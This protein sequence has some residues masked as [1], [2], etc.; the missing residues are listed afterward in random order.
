[1][2]C[3]FH[4]LFPFFLLFLSLLFF[5]LA[6]SFFPSFT[7]SLFVSLSLFFFSSFFFHLPTSIFLFPFAPESLPLC[8]FTRLFTPLVSST[9]PTPF[10][11][12]IS[13]HCPSIY[14][15]LPFSL[16]L[17]LP[18]SL[19]LFLS[20]SSLSGLSDK[21][22][23]AILLIMLTLLLNAL[24]VCL[25]LGVPLFNQNQTRQTTST[26]VARRGKPK[27]KFSIDI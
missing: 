17:T 14:L 12:L 7:S 23:L 16:S 9:S 22:G 20:L 24:G 3:L 2:R 21:R 8:L 10:T 15:S 5:S 1:M 11:S 13:S 26:K 25:C 6:S 27:S 19:S 18:P 4:S